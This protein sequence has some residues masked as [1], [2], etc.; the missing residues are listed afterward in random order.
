MSGR[1]VGASGNMHIMLEARQRLRRWLR[2]AKA[3]ER[4]LKGDFCDAPES[5][6]DA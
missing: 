2:T 5:Y 6:A 1:D 4:S 3:N